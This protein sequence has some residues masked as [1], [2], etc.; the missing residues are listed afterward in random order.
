MTAPDI[1][2]TAESAVEEATV[3][4]EGR[5][6]RVPMQTST[7]QDGYIYGVLEQHSMVTDMQRILS[8]MGDDD[9]VREGLTQFVGRLYR[10]GAIADLLGA[11]LRSQP[12]KWTVAEAKANAD[13]FADVTDPV[14][15]E[16]LNQLAHV[17][18]LSFFVTA[19]ASLST[20][21]ESSPVSEP[22][23][24]ASGASTPPETNATPGATVAPSSAAS[25]PT[26]SGTSPDMTMTPMTE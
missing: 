12:G 16:S 20:S 2:S 5:T 15:K 1:S 25:G 8:R 13:Y 11:T 26:P 10:C 18:L 6:F 14:A 17:V 21:P 23:S 3:E 22:E 19:F 7:R 9:A 24:P 4:I